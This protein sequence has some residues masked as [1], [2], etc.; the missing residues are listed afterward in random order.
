M[1]CSTPGSHAEAARRGTQRLEGKTYVVAGR[2]RP[3]RP[4]QRL[5]RSPAV[6]GPRCCA[7][8]T[9]GSPRREC[10]NCFCIRADWPAVNC[11]WHASYVITWKYTS[12]TA[13]GR[14]TGV[15]SPTSVPPEYFCVS[16]LGAGHRIGDAGSRRILIV[17]L[18]RCGFDV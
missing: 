7:P 18:L 15:V 3:E 17:I 5:R 10:A 14:S 1:T 13:G 2:R 9:P 12:I 4:L 16:R 6:A 8:A 11:V